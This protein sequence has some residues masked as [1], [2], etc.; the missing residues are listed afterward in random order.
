MTHS[1]TCKFTP[2]IN[3]QPHSMLRISNLNF[4]DFP[5]KLVFPWQM[6]TSR[7][8]LGTLL[9]VSFEEAENR[10]R[11]DIVNSRS[12]TQPRSQVSCGQHGAQ[13][14]LLGPRKAPCRPHESCYQGMDCTLFWKR[15]AEVTSG[16]LCQVV[17]ESI[18]DGQR[19]NTCETFPF[20]TSLSRK[21]VWHI[22][23]NMYGT[24]SLISWNCL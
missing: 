16:I 14:G 2:Q 7:M 8:T 6:L 9:T 24:A 11:N 1:I 19:E 10:I 15:D 21:C 18:R 22:C 20:T 3:V 17:T 23:R 4:K 13:R 12:I 5:S